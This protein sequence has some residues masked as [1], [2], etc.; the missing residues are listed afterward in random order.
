MTIEQ[1]LKKAWAAI[2]QLIKLVK[3]AYALG[4]A[5]SSTDIDNAVREYVEAA[6]SPQPSSDKSHVLSSTSVGPPAISDK[7]SAPE[8]L[9]PED[10]K[11][12]DTTSQIATQQF[13]EHIKRVAESKQA[14]HVSDKQQLQSQERTVF[15]MFIAAAIISL[16]I[17]AVGAYFILAGSLIVGILAEVL[18]ALS[19]GGTAILRWVSKRLDVRIKAIDSEQSDNYQVLLAIQ[20]ALSI[21][22]PAQQAQEV[23]VLA[24]WL[25]ERAMVASD[26]RRK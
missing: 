26:K 13:L 15:R 14:A 5:R 16:A 25:R 8:Q 23:T 7:S 3:Q 1:W 10:K 6:E 19:G 9:A 24:A 22:D 20:A 21:P 11:P 4:D 12:I 18:G 17:I 2:K